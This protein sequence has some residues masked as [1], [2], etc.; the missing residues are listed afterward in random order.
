MR[1]FVAGAT[2]ATGQVFV[3][4]AEGLDL[5]L[6]VRPKTADVHPLGRDPRAAVLDLTDAAAL[7]AALTGCDAVLCLVGTMRK[8][9]DT[10]DTYETSD[11]GPTRL[12]VEACKRVGVPRFV[13]MSSFGA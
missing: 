1:V 11:I 12:L 2:G 6:H 8:R 3:R 5:V 9:F 13:L 7:D 10:G 4:E